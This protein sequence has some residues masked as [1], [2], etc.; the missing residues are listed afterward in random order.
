MSPLP[1]TFCWPEPGHVVTAGCGGTWETSS[2]AGWPGAQLRL[3]TVDPGNGEQSLPAS[4]SSFPLCS[5]RSPRPT[6]LQELSS[7]RSDPQGSSLTSSGAAPDSDPLEGPTHTPGPSAPKS[8]SIFNSLC[9]SAL[10][11][12]TVTP[13]KGLLSISYFFLPTA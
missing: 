13:R 2:R 7:P 10:C 6:S 3:E 5:P 1:P 8:D 9:P 11:P 12:L 4:L